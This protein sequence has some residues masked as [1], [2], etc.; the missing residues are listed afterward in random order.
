[1]HYHAHHG[2]SVYRMMTMRVLLQHDEWA[3]L[4]EQ[5]RVADC[6]CVPFLFLK[7]PN[8]PREHQQT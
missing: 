2:F 5:S 7:T 8:Q 3:L 4:M 1:M 6:K